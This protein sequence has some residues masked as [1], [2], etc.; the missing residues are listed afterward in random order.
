MMETHDDAVAFLERQH[1][2]VRDALAVL[3]DRADATTL[4][5]LVRLLTMHETAE[6]MVVY[7]V[8]RSDVPGGDAIAEARLAEEAQGKADLA[9]LESMGVDDPRFPAALASFSDAVLRHATNEERQVFPLLR[10]H[11]DP[12]ALRGMTVT[13]ESAEAT[14]PTHAHPHAPTSG[15]GN[16]IV[17]PF[18]SLFDRIRDVFRGRRAS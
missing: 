15:F 16:L 1:V 2:D 8:L 5:G 12:D 7:P 11:L 3:R 6:E 14:A 17:G 18:V 9:E 10:E 4:D 13:L